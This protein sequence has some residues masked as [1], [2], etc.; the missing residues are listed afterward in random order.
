MSQISGDDEVY[1]CRD[2]TQYNNIFLN[3]IVQCAFDA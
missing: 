2:I 3:V 1:R